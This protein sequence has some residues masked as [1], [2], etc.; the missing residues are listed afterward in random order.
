MVAVQAWHVALQA[1]LQQTPS[2][3][4]PVAHWWPPVGSSPSPALGEARG[5]F[6]LQSPPAA[7]VQK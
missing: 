2:A 6:G 1:E 4:V 3:Q 7:A 5:S